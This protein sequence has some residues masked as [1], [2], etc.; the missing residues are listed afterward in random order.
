MQQRLFVPCSARP[1]AESVQ[2]RPAAAR[3]RRASSSS[4]IH[5]TFFVL[6]AA[7]PCPQDIKANT[8]KAVFKA[9][10]SLTHLTVGGKCISS[11]VIA[12]IA[13]GGASLVD[14]SIF[15]V[16]KARAGGPALPGASTACPPPARPC[17]PP[18]RSGEDCGCRTTVTSTESI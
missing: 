6:H 8:F 2:L 18:P 10:T 5:T 1:A 12:E 15:Q 14:L 17:P 11:Q 7:A 13:R 16:N 3:L 9:L 4:L